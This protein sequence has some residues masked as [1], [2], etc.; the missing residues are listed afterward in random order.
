MIPLP[1]PI[2]HITHIDN[3]PSIL[4]DGGLHCCR[5]LRHGGVTY[6]DIA[7]GHIQ[8]TR[9]STVVPCGPGGTLHEYVPVYFAPRSPMLYAIHGGWVPGYQEGQKPV[10]HLVSSA[11]A[12]ARAGQRF[13]LTDGH[14]TKAFTQFLDTLD[15]LDRVDWTV[16]PL[17]FWNDTRED[18]DRKRRRQAEFLVHSFFPWHLVTEIGVI[19]VEM[20]DRVEA[21]L[22]SV[23]HAPVVSVRRGWYY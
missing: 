9:A 7:Y 13:V 19:S 21:L 15:G 2:Y 6:T 23:S 11:Q 12:V 8:D 14:A 16:M 1:T 18:P 5:V 17:T 10:V 20:K 3:L 4:A 22:R